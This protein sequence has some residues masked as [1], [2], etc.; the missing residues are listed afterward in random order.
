[1]FPK[2][3]HAFAKLFS[4]TERSAARHIFSKA[5]ATAARALA[6][7]F[8]RVADAPMPALPAPGNIAAS[9]TPPLRNI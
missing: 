4:G 6:G 8:I 2:A 3:T 1:V 5:F 9:A 7:T